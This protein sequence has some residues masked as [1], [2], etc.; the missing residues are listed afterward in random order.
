MSGN[1]L[2]I[3]GTTA[4]APVPEPSTYAAILGGAALIGVA[5]LRRR[6][7]ATAA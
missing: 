6:K 1:D 4:L 5:V 3:N 7:R 2:V